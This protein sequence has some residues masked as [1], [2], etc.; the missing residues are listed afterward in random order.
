M[1][2]LNIQRWCVWSGIAMMGF[3]FVG[4]VVAGFIPPPSPNLS[5]A[6]VLRLYQENHTSIRVGLLMANWGAALLVPFTVAIFLLIKRIE[7]GNSPLAY[8][9]LALGATLPLLFIVPQQILLA[10]AFRTDRSAETI[11]ALNDVGWLL[12][13]GLSSTPTLQF[14]VIG[15]AILLDRRPDPICPRWCGYFTLW[16]ALAVSPGSTCIFLKTGPIAWNNLFTWWIP[17][18]AFGIWVPTMTVLIRRDIRRQSAEIAKASTVDSSGAG[19]VSA[20]EGA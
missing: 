14:I 13:I 7:G 1:T 9:Q 20:P 2:Q 4:F 17:A 18:V 6:E 15:A 12:F 11:E 19:A 3:F 16:T 10:A 8:L 5:A